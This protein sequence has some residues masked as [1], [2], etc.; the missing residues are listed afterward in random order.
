[1]SG[2]EGEVG[3]PTSVAKSKSEQI[4]YVQWGGEGL[5]IQLLGGG[6]MLD[7]QYTDQLTSIIVWSS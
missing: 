5:L 6:G 1:M 7:L 3:F 4:P 2:T